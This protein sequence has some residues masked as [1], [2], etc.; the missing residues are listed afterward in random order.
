MDAREVI[1]SECATQQS[2]VYS[3]D[4]HQRKVAPARQRG[5]RKHPYCTKYFKKSSQNVFFDA[6]SRSDLRD[7][8]VRTSI[9]MEEKKRTASAALKNDT[10]VST[11]KTHATGSTHQLPSRSAEAKSMAGEAMK[12]I[13]GMMDK[14]RVRVNVLRSGPATR[15]PPKLCGKSR[16]E[17]E[18][19]RQTEEGRDRENECMKEDT[20]ENSKL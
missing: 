15:R 16:R 14:A 3:H 18:R 20:G 6:T 7:I 2:N 17:R 10:T 11:S 8:R 13:D 9:S 12:R 5:D 1:I 4:I 19:E